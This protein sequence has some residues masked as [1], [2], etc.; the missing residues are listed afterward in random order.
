MMTH[1]QYMRIETAAGGTRCGNRAFI[2]ECRKLL[3]PEGRTREF[4]EIRHEWI[5]DGLRKLN[6]LSG[7]FEEIFGETS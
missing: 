7:T 1:A 3:S 5:R 2:K 6:F 4:R